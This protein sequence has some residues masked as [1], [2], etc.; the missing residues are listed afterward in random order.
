MRTLAFTKES[1]K[2][3]SL[4]QLRSEGYQNTYTLKGANGI[5]CRDTDR[6]FAARELTITL[7]DHAFGPGNALSLLFTVEA[8]DGA[9]GLMII[10]AGG[11]RRSPKPEKAPDLMA[12]LWMAL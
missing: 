8:A 12:A 7:A 10:T 1:Q 3:F 4:E 2:I 11:R 6:H 9:K 5:Y